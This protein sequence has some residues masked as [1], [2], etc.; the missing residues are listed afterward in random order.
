[1]PRGNEKLDK[2]YA[3]GDKAG[4]DGD[5]LDDIIMGLGLPSLIPPH[6]DE[7]DVYSKGYEHGAE[8]RHSGS[9]SD[10]D[11]SSDSDKG[12]CYL[13]T[14]CVTAMGFPDDC[15]E[16]DVLRSFREDVLMKTMDGRKAISEYERMAPRII[17]A[18]HEREG[19]HAMEIFRGLYPDIRIAVQLILSEKYN[20]AFSHYRQMSS[21]LAKAYD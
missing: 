12:G 9:S 18:V 4:R 8:Q 5:L 14:A 6:T 15:F 21:R 16:L 20:E 7:D 17:E 11:N 2:A 1:M 19:S 3:A 13:T 10:S